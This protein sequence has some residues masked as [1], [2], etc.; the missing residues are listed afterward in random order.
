M[1]NIQEFPPLD[2]ALIE[3]LKELFPDTSAELNWSDREVWY[4]S[5]QSSVIKFLKSKFDEQNET[6]TEG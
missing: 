4:R 3:A 1:K 6:I 2:K 5:G